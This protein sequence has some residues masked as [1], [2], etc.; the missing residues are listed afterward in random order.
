MYGV[1]NKKSVFSKSD[2]SMKRM[3]VFFFSNKI[4]VNIDQLYIAIQIG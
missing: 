4:I 3:F 2:L 1:K